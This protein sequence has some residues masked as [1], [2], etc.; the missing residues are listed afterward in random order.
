MNSTEQK[1]RID[2]RIAWLE[3][4]IEVQYGSVFE[5]LGKKCFRVSDDEFFMLTRL[6]WANAIVVEHAESE[7][8]AKSNRFEDGDLFYLDEM[9]KEDM[10]EAILREV[11]E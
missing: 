11:N 7:L 4:Q 9:T 1:K 6:A 5:V 2:E 8:D 10:L 3:Q